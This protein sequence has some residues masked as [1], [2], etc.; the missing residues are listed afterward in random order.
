[1]RRVDLPHIN[2]EDPGWEQAQCRSGDVFAV[3]SEAVTLAKP[4]LVQIRRWMAQ[5]GYGFLRIGSDWTSIYVHSTKIFGT[6]AQLYGE[7]GLWVAVISRDA[8]REAQWGTRCYR[9]DELTKREV[10]TWKYVDSQSKVHERNLDLDSH[11][12]K[13]A[14]NPQNNRGGSWLTPTDAQS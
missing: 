6:S 3:N 9:A 13:W 12:I 1:M 4:V 14:L 5:Q 2:V 7:S 8:R 10:R 11:Q